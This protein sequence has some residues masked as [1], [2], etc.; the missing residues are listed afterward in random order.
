MN[1][2]AVIRAS[3]SSIVINVPYSSVADEYRKS[4]LLRLLREMTVSVSLTSKYIKLNVSMSLTG[5][6][7]LKHEL[8]LLNRIIALVG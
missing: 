2:P 4:N 1:F 7:S 3:Y 5:E 8:V 6:V